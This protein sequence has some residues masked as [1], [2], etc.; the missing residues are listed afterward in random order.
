[1]VGSGFGESN[2]QAFESFSTASLADYQSDADYESRVTWRGVEQSGS[3]LG[4]YPRGRVFKSRSRNQYRESGE[5]RESR[6]TVNPFPKG[7]LVQ[8]QPFPPSIRSSAG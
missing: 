7:E 6:R 5:V 3:S 2:E 1:M 4:S 8:I